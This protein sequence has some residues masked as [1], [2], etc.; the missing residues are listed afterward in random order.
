M[1]KSAEVSWSSPHEL[2]MAHFLCLSRYIRWSCKAPSSPLLTSCTHFPMD[3]Q[4]GNRGLIGVDKTYNLSPLHVTPMVF[5]HL[6]L[7]RTGSESNHPLFLGPTMIH[8]NSDYQTWKFPH[9]IH[10][11]LDT[12]SEIAIGSNKDKALC[13]AITRSFPHVKCISCE[14]HLQ[15]NCIDFLRGKVGVKADTC[16]QIIH[17]IFGH[18]TG[19][20]SSDR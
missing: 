14:R 17:A 1:D 12:D 6:G 4:T 19:L 5:K 2:T 8:S 11:A 13:K 10:T 20:M 3:W 16:K 18:N 15:N 7:Q 9:T